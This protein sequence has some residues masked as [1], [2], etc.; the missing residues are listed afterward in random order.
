[1]GTRHYNDGTVIDRTGGKVLQVREGPVAED[2]RLE[3]LRNYLQNTPGARVEDVVIT[4]PCR[5]PK[6]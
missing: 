5:M 3:D 1:M 6:E 4:A 2:I